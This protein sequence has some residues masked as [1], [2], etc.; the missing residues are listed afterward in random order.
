M[1]LP[2]M[3]TIIIS[4]GIA[5]ILLA[6][7]Y[8]LNRRPNRQLRRELESLRQ[9]DRQL[10]EKLASLQE[11]EKKSRSLL[12]TIPSIVFT[13]YM[14]GSAEFLDDKFEALTGYPVEEFNSHRMKWSDII[15]PEDVADAKAA[16]KEALIGDQFYLRE[17]RIKT[18]SGNVLW[19]RERGQIN[20]DDH[21]KVDYITGICSDITKEHE[22]TAALAK[23]QHRNEIILN[24]LGDGLFELDCR[25]EVSF[26]NPAALKM[27]GYQGKDVVGQNLHELIHHKKADGSPY[28]EADCP[29][30][31]TLRD[32][33][34]HC[35]G[36]EVFW[37]KRGEV[38]PV[39]C[40]TT[41][42]IE[43]GAV[44][45][46]VGTFRDITWRKQAEAEFQR[47][48]QFLE[49]V[50]D[51]SAEG[52]GIVDPHGH[53]TK[54]NKAAEVI[55]GYTFK[56]LQ[57][58]PASDLYAHREEM[59]KM[60]IPL[61]RDGF[62]K[63][64]EITM[65]RRDGSTF[66]A[67]LSIKVMRDEAGKNVGSVAV[68][69][70]L[71]ELKEKEA[72]LHAA[73]EQLRGLVDESNERSRQVLLLREMSE[74]FQSCQT[75]GE[76]YSAIT[77]FGPKFFPDYAGVLY[78]L[79]CTKDLFE[80]TAVWGEAPRMEVSFGNDECW[81][82]R[83]SR[84]YPVADS[85]ST[86]N[87]RHVAAPLPGA[88]LCVPMMAQGEVMGI[89]HLRKMTQEIKEQMAVIAQFAT[90]LA[91][92]MALALGNLKLRE[93]LRNQAI[94]DSLT[95]LFN[96][97]Y[98]EETLDR[99]LSRSKRQGS[100]LGVIMLDLDHFKEYN[101]AYGHTAGDELL[102]SLGELIQKQVRREDIACRY[103]G[104]EFLLIMPGAPLEVA[105]NRAK[106]LN[107]SVKNLHTRNTS[108][109]P[110][111]I[112]AGVAIFPDHGDAGKEVIRAADAA[113]YR[114]KAKG[115]DRVLVANGGANAKVLAN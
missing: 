109:K 47:S 9:D 5:L 39:A 58:K 42:V 65:K 94:R 79:N 49:N 54:W 53:I 80:M 95:G 16:F 89:L 93:T 43:N 3:T 81:S 76:T 101:D 77:Y 27:L 62:V 78:L 35:L 46:V 10:R 96:R 72:K 70:D 69:R 59:A 22:I 88:Y 31:A 34:E 33:K 97:R 114:A 28:P 102:I 4:S 107:R 67:S 38:L 32:G 55:Y 61:R 85:G 66:P 18:A 83:R 87:C 6:C 41:P 15:L 8:L 20:Y 24:S 44:V 90:S 63:H 51:S 100:P 91:E 60:M 45:G 115:R 110:I 73:N 108:L 74:I 14:D 48:R 104:E 12:K 2:Q 98:L 103:G 11:D 17:Y 19:I 64:Y 56:E 106:E 82:L 50:I 75:S 68:A 29:I 99:E 40:V 86:M 57:G 1:N 84:A 52:I 7:M 111:T 13:G 71:T 113:L 23:M 26:I 30:L 37:S 92:A 112:S 25:G 36:D 21:G 105:L